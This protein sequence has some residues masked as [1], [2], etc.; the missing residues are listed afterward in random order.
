[1]RE[2]IIEKGR[3]RCLQ[4]KK[5]REKNRERKIRSRGHCRNMGVHRVSCKFR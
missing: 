3:V 4:R 2:R 1:M 5:E